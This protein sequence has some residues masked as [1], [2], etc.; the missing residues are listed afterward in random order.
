M[1]CS[2]GC[3]MERSIRIRWNFRRD[4]RWNIRRNVR[5]NVYD[6]SFDGMSVQGTVV[7]AW[8]PDLPTRASSVFFFS[9]HADG[10]RR[11]PVTVTGGRVG[12]KGI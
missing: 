11:G 8:F 2:M 4:V 6:A 1:I 7:M 10:E 9:E 3:S 5:W 12:S